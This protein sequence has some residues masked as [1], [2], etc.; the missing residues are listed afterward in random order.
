M[1]QLGSFECSA[2]TA[3]PFGYEEAEVRFGRTAKKW[4]IS[5]L[6]DPADWLSLLDEY[7]TWRDIKI[8]EEDTAVSGVVGA[9]VSFTA[10]GPGGQSWASSCWFASAP[11]GEQAGVKILVKF[12]VVDAAEALQVLLKQQE[13][14]T[15][16]DA[17]DLGTYTLGGVVL[18]L[19]K[20][21][22]AYREGP[23]IQLSS[24]GNH[25]VTGPLIA[26]KVNDIEGTTNASGWN[27]IRAWYEGEIEQPV[28]SGG[29]F[30]VG[31]PQASAAIKIVG[32]AKTTQYTV[33]IQLLEIV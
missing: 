32:G 5:G 7:D 17:P 13:A 25:Y 8:Q 30:P 22:N 9:T 26:E 31:P 12:E 29:L 11:S 21:I 10:D 1:I 28:F 6:V 2:L 16:E 18:T 14:E 15:V 23:K 3:Q 4:A 19:L 27:S 20:P 33:S 24:T